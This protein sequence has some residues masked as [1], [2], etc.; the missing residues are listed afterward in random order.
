MKNMSQLLTDLKP[1]LKYGDMIF[2]KDAQVKTMR[3]QVINSSLDRL[4]EIL[5]KVKAT[6]GA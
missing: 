5:N 2:F 1:D 4:V 6:A 3:T